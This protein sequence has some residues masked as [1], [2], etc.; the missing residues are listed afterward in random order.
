MS[1]A[2][3]T[4]PERPSMIALLAGGAASRRQSRQRQDADPQALSRVERLLACLE[5]RHA[6]LRSPEYPLE[7][8]GISLAVKQLMQGELTGLG[9]GATVWPAAHVLAKYLERRCGGRGGLAGCRVI[10]LGAGTGA[11]GLAAALLGAEVVLTDQ[12]QLAF[13][14][15]EN[16]GRM[17]A[18]AAAAD[19]SNVKAAVAKGASKSSPP[20]PGPV[21]V[22][23]YDWGGPDG[24][25][26]A[27][28]F[29]LVI[30]S[31]C[32]L[33][34]LY[35]IKP[36]VDA[37]VELTR[38]R[39]HRGADVNGGGD[40]GGKS[41]ES[42]E[43]VADSGGKGGG[44]G[45]LGGGQSPVVLMSYEHRT[46]PAFDPRERFGELCAAQGLVRRVVAKSEL[47]DLYQADD[48]EVWEVTRADSSS[49]GGGCG[50][51]GPGP[52][53][54]VD[55]GGGGGPP[56][57]V[58]F[59]LL[60][61]DGSGGEGGGGRGSGDDSGRGG[62]SGGGGRA[63]EVSVEVYKRRCSLRL[64]LGSPGGDVSGDLWASALRLSQHLLDT[65]AAH[66]RTA[67]SG[68]LDSGGGGASGGGG[69]SGAL[70]RARWLAGKRV[71]ELGSGVG[72]VALVAAALGA[73]DVVATD[74]GAASMA[75]L[76]S[77]VLANVGAVAA[78]RGSVGG[79]GSGDGDGG[80]GGSDGGGGGGGESSASGG[81]A[82]S[83]ADAAAGVVRV[84]EFDWAA[85]PSRETLFPHKDAAAA[86]VA[87]GR[88]AAAD[89]GAA[90]AAA[91]DADEAVDVVLC[92]DCLYAA[93]SV[94][95]LLAALNALAV[96]GRTTVLL[97]N[98]LRTALDGFLPQLSARGFEVASLGI[99]DVRGPGGSRPVALF[100]AVKK[101]AASPPCV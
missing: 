43:S 26:G 19:A 75:L 6:H 90:D 72:L 23:T 73:R 76:A 50:S 8:A 42:G 91:T 38:P 37:L 27:L 2:P 12:A 98:E 101:A 88:G 47:D 89:A 32:V 39:G 55:R 97:A 31:D 10:D 33:P 46:Y 67:T 36:L 60:P 99:A 77:N 7:V 92:A 41:D 87:E 14:M 20:P 74:K 56:G 78:A 35:P 62:R 68:G 95:P 30:V 93:G 81:A 13:L 11:V 82:T 52:S 58:T 94:G 15:E 66:L 51:D 86:A 84:A 4:P 21:T 85:P 59:S 80:C 28:P 22:A 70:M 79:G 1:D 64:S 45:G 5:W 49:S 57:E 96:P 18:A 40:S 17:L 53:A 44:G 63:V 24:H 29:D 65:D 71:V 34:K 54:A 25:L 16:A 83:E 100:S 3:P 61:G 48:I 9:T 69:G